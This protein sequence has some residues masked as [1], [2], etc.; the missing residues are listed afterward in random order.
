MVAGFIPFPAPQFK[1]KRP[2]ARGRV[3]RSLVRVSPNPPKAKQPIDP[4]MDTL[5]NLRQDALDEG[6]Y[7]TAFI[8]AIAQNAY[9]NGL[10]NNGTT[11]T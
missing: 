9:R 1:R 2:K 8:A 5:E 6:E 7:G 10:K 3:R 11:T 4:F